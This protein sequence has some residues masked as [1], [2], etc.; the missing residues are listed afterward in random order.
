MI[1]IESLKNYL[2]ILNE[3]DYKKLCDQIYEFTKF[4]CKDYP[5]YKDW[6]YNKQ[7][8][9]VSTPHGEILFAREK[10]KILAVASLKKYQKE[11][12]ICTLYI[13]NE[14]RYKHL[15]T[16]MVEASAKFLCTTKPLITLADYK[17]P[18]FKPLIDK[19]DW[20]LIETVEGLYNDKSKE[21]CFNGKLT[22][23]TTQK[24][25]K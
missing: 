15:G 25:I 7:I 2:K 21:L 14:Y 23:T 11:K 4:I 24:K 1:K 5:N 6:Y 13:K 19:Y 12:K 20:K 18:M 9:R 16:K 8:P 3:D 10:G 17:L 22:K